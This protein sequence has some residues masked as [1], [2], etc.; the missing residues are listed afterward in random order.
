LKP[1]QAIAPV[2]RKCCIGTE[3]GKVATLESRE[4]QREMQA[5]IDFMDE[6]REMEF[7]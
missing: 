5:N 2:Y 4:K 6:S 1:Q 3:T 7:D